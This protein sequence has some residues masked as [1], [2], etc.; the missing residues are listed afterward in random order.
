[1]II[2]Q[3][4]MFL[5]NKPGAMASVL[6]LLKANGINLRA[7]TLADSTDFGG[8]LRLVVRDPERAEVLLRDAGYLVRNDPVLTF[9]L[10]DDTGSFYEKLLR[11]SQVGINIEYTYAFAASHE[12]GARA[13][14][15]TASPELADRLLK[16]AHDIGDEDLPQVYW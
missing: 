12:S 10:E 2:R 3:I 15:K 14:V 7:L 8:T 5:E 4:S 6:G 13:V 1:M 16:D 11:L 9:A